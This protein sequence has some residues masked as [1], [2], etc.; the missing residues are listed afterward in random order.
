MIIFKLVRFK[1]LLSTGNNFT[2]IL[3]DD[4]NT[5]LIAGLNGSGKSTFLDAI[6][7]CLY[8]NA[9]R[10]INKPQLVN[11]INNKQL[12]VEIEFT[13]NDVEYLV[14][15]GQKPNVFEIHKDGM[16]INQSADARDYQKMLENNILKMNEKSFRQIVV[17]GSAN[18]IPFMKLTPAD[19]R[20]VI[21]DILDIQIFSSMNNLVKAKIDE[22]DRQLT[23]LDHQLAL[24]EQ[25]LELIRA[26]Q[27]EARADYEGII[28]TKQS[29]IADLTR[30]TNE[31]RSEI[32]RLQEQYRIVKDKINP[33]VQE[34]TAEIVK[35][36][37]KI[38]A[39]IK[40]TEK[41]IVFYESNHDCPTCKQSISD[42][43]R[44]AYLLALGK[45]HEDFLGKSRSIADKSAKNRIKL[46]KQKEIEKE[47]Q[48]IDSSIQRL[49]FQINTNKKLIKSLKNEIE[50]LTQQLKT[51]Y[52]AQE[53]VHLGE[54]DLSNIKATKHELTN[55]RNTLGYAVG[56]LKDSGIKARI[57]KQYVPIMN[58]CINNYLKSMEFFIDFTLDE[59]FKETIMS[60]GRDNF[61]YNSFSEGEKMRIDL[62]ILFTWR[63]IAKLRRSSVTNLL[64]LDEIFDSALD[65]NG[66][67]EF[68]KIVQSLTNDTNTFIISPKS[69]F[70]SDKIDKVLVFKK[71]KNFSRLTQ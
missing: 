42:S 53:N 47:L 40:K 49:D 51:K 21:E 58:Q 69:E 15:R 59:T 66:I 10:N 33:K 32:G 13:I 11:S 8:N 67:D 52:D 23:R 71:S 61:T 50:G 48:S 65:H 56:L 30:E 64:I 34:K 27:A 37:I 46:E 54:S 45:K 12:L 14:R 26:H 31:C 43:F 5:T 2:E 28:Q 63:D 25:R 38:N 70:I 24:E 55:R 4:S 16:L 44:N 6:C 62:S 9:Y 39:A 41:E 17:L 35:Y 22:N 1:N 7:Y 36:E 3:L 68:I 60:I 20:K 19:R 57:I 18:Y 29:K